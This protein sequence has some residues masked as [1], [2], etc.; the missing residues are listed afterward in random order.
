VITLTLP[1]GLNYIDASTPPSEI[2]GN[3]LIWQVDDLPPNMTYSPILV[4]VQVDVAAPLLQTVVTAV[5]IA[6]IST[7]IEILNNTT[8]FSTFIGYVRLVP[9]LDK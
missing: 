2:I 3:Q 6:T 4:T 8:S 1:V 7:E 5:E 9:I